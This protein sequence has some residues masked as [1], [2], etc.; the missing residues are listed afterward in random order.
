MVVRGNSIIIK[1]YLI[2]AENGDHYAIN[3]L[4]S[5]YN[6]IKDINNMVK[7]CDDC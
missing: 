7:Y 6:K 3:N 5:Y 4:G 1:Y 2:A